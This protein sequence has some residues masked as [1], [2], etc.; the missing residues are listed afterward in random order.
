MKGVGQIGGVR[1]G[2]DIPP[3]S[4]L[5]ETRETS[6]PSAF[7][8]VTRLVVPLGFLI[9]AVSQLSPESWGFWIALGVALL[10]FTIGIYHPSKRK[11]QRWLAR[12]RDNR[13]AQDAF[14]QLQQFASRFG[15]FV[16][17]GNG[18]RLGE[19]VRKE[20][21]QEH[22]TSREELGASREKIFEGFYRHLNQRLERQDP[23]LIT[24]LSSF[25]E[26]NN[27]VAQYLLQTV[28]PV[29]RQI[30]RTT[31]TELPDDARRE[32]ESFRLRLSRYL[33]RYEEF[34]EEFEESL[35]TEGLPRWHFP[36]PKP[37]P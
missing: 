5:E 24:T 19:I 7:E 33:D 1:G 27:L 30:P 28:R 26:F 18:D 36:Y 16:E 31:E 4:T 8:Y 17:S 13:R 35:E 29:Y 11:V 12:R 3:G 20:L 37:L 22:V 34:L 25:S 32:L 14:P 6:R 21:K 23:D 2:G 10:S 9:V 15:E